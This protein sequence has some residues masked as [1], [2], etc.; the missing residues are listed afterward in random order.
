MNI[1]V[2]GI[3]AG[4]AIF[5][6]ALY[7][8]P[9]VDG[10]DIAAS[11]AG[12]GSLATL[13]DDIIF[14]KAQVRKLKKDGINKT[15]RGRDDP[16]NGKRGKRGKPKKTKNVRAKTKK[17]KPRKGKPAKVK[18]KGSPSQ[19]LLFE[20]VNQCSG[21]DLD[22]NNCV[23]A[24]I[25]DTL[26]S[27]PATCSPDNLCFNENEFCNFDKGQCE[28]CE[29]SCYG[30]PNLDEEGLAHCVDVCGDAEAECHQDKP[31][32]NNGLFCNFDGGADRGGACEMCP[33]NVDSCA[34]LNEEAGTE[35]CQEVCSRENIRKRLLQNDQCDGSAPDLDVSQ[36]FILGFMEREKCM[37]AGADPI[38]MNEFGAIM[39]SYMV[40][41]GGDDCWDSIMC[42]T[43]DAL[44][45]KVIIELRAE[46]TGV[47][48]YDMNECIKE[49]SINWLFSPEGHFKFTDKKKDIVQEMLGVAQDV[50]GV[51][52]DDDEMEYVADVFLVILTTE[53]C[54]IGG[55]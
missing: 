28:F 36:L 34:F 49:E 33:L 30:I 51:T 22:R 7:M 9:S 48:I 29:E 45:Q 12:G 46:C 3:L 27:G 13:Y 1:I 38:S 24:G 19:F 14:M 2:S 26:M 4:G 17:G 41:L 25:Y 40:W 44:I 15:T 16:R 31:C 50:C 53:E 23:V 55:L 5:L 43:E 18:V 54:S 11:G 32:G 6:S 21:A 42:G 10:Q 8:L 35:K 37:E 47:D 39:E 20:Y 52:L